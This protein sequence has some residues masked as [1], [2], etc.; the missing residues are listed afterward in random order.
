[1]R[2]TCA[3]WPVTSWPNTGRADR[4]HDQGHASRTERPG[5]RG[6]PGH[7][8]GHRRGVRRRRSPGDDLLAESGPAAAGGGRRRRTRAAG[9]DRVAGRARRQ[10]GGRAGLRGGD[11]APARLGRHPGQ[12]RRHQPVLRRPGRAGPAPGDQDHR[13]QPAGHA[14]LGSAGLA[15]VDARARR[16][17]HQH[18]LG[19]RHAGRA[20]HR[21]LQRDQGG[22]DPPDPPAGL[23]DGPRGAGQRDRARADQ[24]RHGP[25]AL[26][27]P[28]DRAVP[29]DPAAAPGGDRRHR[30]RRAVPGLRRGVLDHRAH[31][32]RGRR[33]DRRARPSRRGTS[34]T[35]RG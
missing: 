30:Q 34:R 16:R 5:H 24:D 19:R 29:A 9:P 23:R 8:P 18:H 27:G 32:R 15:R 10:A 14:H 21:L 12:Q 1:M 17:D 31:A 11:R 6:F 33:R 2:C 22:G 26:G 20:G 3:R 4:R 7:R 13:G 28:G 35:S 25:R